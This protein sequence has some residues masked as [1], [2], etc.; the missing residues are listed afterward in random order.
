MKLRVYDLDVNLSEKSSKDLEKCVPYKASNVF[1]E[2][3]HPN[4]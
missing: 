2:I 1:D 4:L 3:P